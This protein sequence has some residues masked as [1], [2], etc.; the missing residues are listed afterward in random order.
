MKIRV[1]MFFLFP[2]NGAPYDKRLEQI[3]DTIEQGIF[4]ICNISVAHRFF[5]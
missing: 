1:K 2:K 5:H 4:K 3:F